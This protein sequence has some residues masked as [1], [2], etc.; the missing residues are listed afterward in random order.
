MSETAKFYTE[1]Q[2]DVLKAEAETDRANKNP[3]FQSTGLMILDTIGE[4]QNTLQSIERTLQRI[5]Q[6]LSAEKQEEYIYNAVSHAMLGNK[7]KPTLKD[8]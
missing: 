6:L 5:D 7:Y 3:M 8:V 1:E 4:Q 2:K